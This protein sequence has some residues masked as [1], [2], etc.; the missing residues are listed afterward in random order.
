MKSERH[1]HARED[2]DVFGQK[3]ING[4][5]ETLG[6]DG[7]DIREEVCH[8]T[9]GMDACVGPAGGGEPDR[10]SVHPLQ[11]GLNS[12]LHGPIL[13]LNL[14][15]GEIRPVVGDDKLDVSLL[16]GAVRSRG[17]DTLKDF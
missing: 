12:A 3:R 16:A 14:P 4:V 1:F 11:G 9:G 5:P 7:C 17:L 10:M 8:L 15:A 6:R 2:P 13:V